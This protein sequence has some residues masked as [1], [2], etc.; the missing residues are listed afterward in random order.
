MSVTYTA[1]LPAGERTVEFLA[2]LLAAERL[3]RGTRA[4][5]VYNQAILIL[6]WFCDGT[7]MGQ[8]ARDN[9]ISKST[10]YDYLHEGIDVLAARAP[11]LHGG[12][13]PRKPLAT[14]M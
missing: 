6:R 12:C 4:L 11:S 1:V 5:S 7:R 8:L 3:R 13:W 9:A 10:G 2:G 14:A